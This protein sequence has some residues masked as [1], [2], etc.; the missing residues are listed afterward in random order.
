MVCTNRGLGSIYRQDRNL[1]LH[2]ALPAAG[3]G[4]DVPKP[5]SAL[6]H[7]TRHSVSLLRCLRIGVREQP[8]LQ[9]LAGGLDLLGHF[10][11]YGDRRLLRSLMA[12]KLCPLGASAGSSRR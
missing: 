11:G 3:V 12:P 8:W 10:C 4:A 2:K 6:C 7:L 9:P 5:L 1:V